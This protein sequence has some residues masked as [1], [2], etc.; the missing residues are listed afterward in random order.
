MD[1]SG[2]RG[3]AEPFWHFSF[4]GISG[5]CRQNTKSDPE[6]VRPALL[7]QHAGKLIAHLKEL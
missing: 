5:R 1:K 7:P 3:G 6:K 2:S 4:S